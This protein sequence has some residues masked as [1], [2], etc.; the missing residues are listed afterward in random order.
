M[1][2][3]RLSRSKFNNKMNNNKYHNFGNITKSNNKIEEI[4]KIDI[5]NKYMTAPWL[6]TGTLM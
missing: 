5:P 2:H 4:C 1:I 6:D 3:D